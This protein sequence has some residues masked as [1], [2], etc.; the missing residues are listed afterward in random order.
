MT[1]ADPVLQVNFVKQFV[2]CGYGTGR[3]E[4]W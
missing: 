3:N 4:Y 1:G 2:K